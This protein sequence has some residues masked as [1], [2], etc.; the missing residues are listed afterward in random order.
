[1]SD[2]TALFKEKIRLRLLLNTVK[3]NSNYGEDLLMFRHLQLKIM[4]NLAKL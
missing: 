1:M 4:M 2:I 3:N